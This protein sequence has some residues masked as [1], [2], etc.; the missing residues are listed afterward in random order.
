V[1][2][3]RTAKHPTKKRR[4]GQPPTSTRKAAKKK[5]RR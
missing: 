4:T 5:G 3:H 2:K 1:K